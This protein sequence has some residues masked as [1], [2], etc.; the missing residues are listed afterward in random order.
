MQKYHNIKDVIDILFFVKIFQGS[1]F[2]HKTP[3]KL[4][5]FHF[6]KSIQKLEWV[7]NWYI[8]FW[9]CDF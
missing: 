7:L 5:S 2:K 6:G 3:M 9:K 8:L 1:I 4:K